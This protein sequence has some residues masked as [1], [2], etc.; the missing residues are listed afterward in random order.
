MSK[1]YDLK[2]CKCGRIH[3]IDNEKLEK[4]LKHDKDLLLICG[5][6]GAAMYRGA[7]IEPDWNDPSKTVYMMYT[8]DFSTHKDKSVVASDFES[9]ENQKGIEEIIYSHGYKVPM[10]TGEYATGYFDGRFYDTCYPDFYELQRNDITA[11]EVKGFI[12]NFH[13]NR[14]TVNMDRFIS[15][16]PED[17]LE[18]ISCYHIKGFSWK[19]TKWER[20]WNS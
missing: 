1:C 12:K 8:Y 17:V 9:T 15:E 10:M 13:H 19:G 4:A 16:T 20:E 14:T 7:D 11:K 2:I 3:M 5:G 18:K 6:C